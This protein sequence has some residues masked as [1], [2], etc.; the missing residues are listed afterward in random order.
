MI[1]GIGE[2]VLDIVFR[3]NQPER[4]IP[5]GSVFNSMISLGR[6]GIECAMI[7]Q[8]GDDQVGDL[9]MDYLRQNG[10]ETCYMGRCTGMKSHISLAFL[11]AN[12]DAQYSFYKDHT[13]WTPDSLMAAVEPIRFTKKDALL[14]G[15][16]FAVN[17]LV[18]PAVKLLLHRAHEA[19]AIIYYDLNYRR[20]HA[21]QLCEVLPNIEENI[22][23][24]TIVRASKDDLQIVGA[25]ITPTIETD[26][27]RPI[28]LHTPHGLIT[29]DTPS[30]KPVS[31]IGAGDNFNAGFLYRYTQMQLPPT[32]ADWTKEQWI[33]LARTG[34]AFGQQVCLSYENSITERIA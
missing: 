18:R 20:P 5:G 15:S 16:F 32:P 30:I 26:G 22:S 7:A 9:T 10:V 31:T 1:Y 28:K 4:A 13:A 11:D 6:S 19:G 24:S 17:P 34:Q 14:I 3:N 8:T 2:T 25:D 33:E 29:L 12:S 21:S 27:P 23:L